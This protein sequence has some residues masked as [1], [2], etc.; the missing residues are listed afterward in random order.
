MGVGVSILIVLASFAVMA[1]IG[2]FV[3]WMAS[4]SGDRTR[5]RMEANEKAMKRMQ[6]KGTRPHD[7]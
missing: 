5:A 3:I 6:H 7:K 1:G 2:L 4:R